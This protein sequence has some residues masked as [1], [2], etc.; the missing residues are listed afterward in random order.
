MYVV[1]VVGVIFGT[2]FRKFGFGFYLSTAVLTLVAMTA[3]SPQADNT[4]HFLN[5]GVNFSGND[6]LLSA[7][8]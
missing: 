8:G 5:G 7:S 1:D 4:V 6:T 2:I 3:S